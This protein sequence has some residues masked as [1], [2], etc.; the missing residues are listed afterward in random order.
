MEE[1]L[2]QSGCVLVVDD[3]PSI[4]MMMSE[5]LESSV[6]TSQRLKMEHGH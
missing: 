4:R 2:T 6:S 5:A 3:D 1:V